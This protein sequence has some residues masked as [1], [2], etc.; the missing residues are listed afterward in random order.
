MRYHVLTVDLIRRSGEK[1]RDFGHSYVGSAHFL[2]ALAETPGGTGQFLRSL[3]MDP[4]L[5]ETMAR[6]FYGMG[7]P[8]LPL[9]QGLT[10]HAKQ[11]LRCA[12]REAQQQGSRQVSPMHILLALARVSDTAAA[13]LLQLSGISQE[14]LFTHAVEYMQWEAL[15]SR[16]VMKDISESGVYVGVPAHKK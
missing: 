16:N 10:A 11:I 8:D 4:A 13:E 12:S 9:P 15:S 7:K 6:L 5:T 14:M 1:A 3:G 2:A